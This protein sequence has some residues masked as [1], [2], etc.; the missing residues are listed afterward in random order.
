MNSRTFESIELELFER[1]RCAIRRRLRWDESRYKR[2]KWVVELSGS[3]GSTV[4][5]RRAGEGG[6]VRAASQDRETLGGAWCES[7]VVESKLARYSSESSGF[8]PP[9]R[10]LT[11]VAQ[12]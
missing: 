5:G 12:P 11:L 1:T 7:M 6:L 2:S 3:R 4:I 8:S 10:T 9:R